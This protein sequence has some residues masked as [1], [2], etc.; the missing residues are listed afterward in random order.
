MTVTDLYDRVQEAAAVV[1]QRSSL[2]PEAAIILGTGLGGLVKEI[3]A[4]R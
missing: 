3:Q 1:R 4:I 2:V